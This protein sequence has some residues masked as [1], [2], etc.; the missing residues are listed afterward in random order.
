LPRGTSDETWYAQLTTPAPAQRPTHQAGM[1]AGD[2]HRGRRIALA[3]A[4]A[5]TLLTLWALTH[6]YRGFSRDGELYAVQAMARVQPSLGADLYLKNTSQDR[7]TIFSPIYAAFIK[8]LGL[9]KAELVLFSL[10]AVWF[11][12]AAWNAARKLSTA[13]EAWLSV[14]FLIVTVGY[15]GAYQ[16]F[17]Y[18]EN[19]L[20]ARSLGE[21][22]T[23]TA[24]AI[25][26][27]GRRSL[28]LLIGVLALFVHPL[29]A[30]PGV[31]LLICLWL[32]GRLALVCAAAGV[33]ATLAFAATAAGVP[34]SSPI[35]AVMDAEWL[36]VVR[37]RSQFLFL[38][39]WSTADWEIA[40][41]PFV[42]LTLT[43]MVTSD[44]R[45]R[46]LS[47]TAMLIGACGMAVGT[48][49]CTVGPIAVLLQGQ[50]WRWMWVTAFVSVLLLAPTLGRVWRDDRCGPLCAILLVLGWTYSIVDG[51]ACV[52]AALVLWLL[53]PYISI[54]AVK[55]LKW[56]AGAVCALILIWILAN[57][58]TF[59][60]AP[61]PESGRESIVIGR[62]REVFGLGVSGLLLTWV[63]W[64]A[65]RRLRSLWAISLICTFFLAAA[66]WILPGSV[67]QLDTV[68]T[69]AEMH[70]FADW[71]AAIPPS[72]N[73]LLIP[74]RKSASFTWFTLLR[75]SYI[76]VDQSA[77][78]VFSRAT[79]LEVRRRSEVLLP[80]MD[81]DWKILT[82]IMGAGSKRSKGASAAT[83]SPEPKPLTTKALVGVC[84]DP[85]LGF[86]IAKEDVGFDPMRHTHPGGFKN[87]N[88]YDCRRVRSAVPEA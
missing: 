15:Y 42:S 55:Y 76:S 86:V 53:R 34:F 30:L 87:W 85:E 46:K 33:F 77:G 16:I 62:L 68:G 39:Y 82:S 29:M 13:D 69:A 88:L 49:A 4:F 26:L 9:Q 36:E 45:I 40:A 65:I 22:L 10:C 60:S 57:C 79:S 64:R 43:A 41:R 31:L 84:S 5:L 63:L 28:A 48:I 75:P 66:A 70:D 56:A 81:P 78:V 72:S 51:L 6:R 12:T 74:T 11:L 2:G 52:S 25:H 18:S 83:S 59:A 80:L 3:I 50:A 19:Y 20:T 8:A 17:T 37:E 1:R 73:V 35:A 47:L 54:A 14:A 61:I 24:L 23:V 67:K 58:W 32:P 7:Y 71:R 38:K 27:S 21:A 44:P